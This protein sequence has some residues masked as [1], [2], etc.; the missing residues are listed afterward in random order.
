MGRLN[1][2]GNRACPSL[3]QFSLEQL[4]GITLVLAS[5]RLLLTSALSVTEWIASYAA[6]VVDREEL[7]AEVDAYM[8]DYDKKIAE[9]R[10]G[11]GGNLAKQFGERK[12]REKISR[13]PSL[14]GK[15]RGK[16]T[17]WKGYFTPSC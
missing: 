2:S 8:Q 12:G 4:K 17:G 13:C 11:W 7:K 15:G 14:S 3:Q 6:S 1:R 10:P 5:N 16:H 9:V